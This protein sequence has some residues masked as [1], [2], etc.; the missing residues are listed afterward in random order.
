MFSASPYAFSV[1]ARAQ[2]WK[3]ACGSGP[4]RYAYLRGIPPSA[5][6]SLFKSEVPLGLLAEAL[7]VLNDNW[8]AAA[9][10]AE[11]AGCSTS[12]RGGG[13]AGGSPA[14]S[15]ALGEAAAVLSS[16]GA[17]AGAGR[18]A[19]TRALLPAPAKA[20]GKALFGALEAAARAAEARAGP[21]IEGE[22]G[23]R[24]GALLTLKQV[25]DTRALYGL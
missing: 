3:R 24:R 20:A 5:L 14:P 2:A 15:S 16:L 10:A 13:G 8:L 21:E 4:E 25:A 17:V 6:A 18:F 11:E 9:G 19:L 7:G 23:D 22:G 12:A 1:P